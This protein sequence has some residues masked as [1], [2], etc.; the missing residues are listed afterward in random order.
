MYHINQLLYKIKRE[1]I[2]ST[3]FWL[4]FIFKL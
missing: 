1:Q 3:L 4:W 2:K